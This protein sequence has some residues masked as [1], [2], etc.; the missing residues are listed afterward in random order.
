M[1]AWIEMETKGAD[2]GD[3]RL[4]AR[5]QVLLEQLSDKPSLS[6]PAACGG[7]AETMAAYGFFKNDKTTPAKVLSPHGNATLQRIRAEAVVIAAQDTTE[8]D[9]TR[10]HEKV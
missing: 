4:Q 3:E 2:F 10:Q 7:E 9:L 6:I 1:Q 5:Y 8:V